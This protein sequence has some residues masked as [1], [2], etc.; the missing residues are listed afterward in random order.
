MAYKKRSSKVV[1]YF[2]RGML[3]FRVDQCSTLIGSYTKDEL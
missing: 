2:L 1:K 3:K